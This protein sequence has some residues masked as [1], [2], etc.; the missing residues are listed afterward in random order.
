V[1]ENLEKREENGTRNDRTQID[2]GKGVLS[3]IEHFILEYLVRP[4]HVVL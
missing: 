2:H 4:E 1:K 3:R